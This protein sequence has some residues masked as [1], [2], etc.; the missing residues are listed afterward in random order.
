[1][2]RAPERLVQERIHRVTIIEIKIADRIMRHFIG[3]AGDDCLC[4]RR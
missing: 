4:L 3:V 2:W 1:M